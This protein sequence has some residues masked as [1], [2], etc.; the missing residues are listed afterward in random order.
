MVRHY[1]RVNTSWSTWP[2]ICHS[3]LSHCWQIIGH[4]FTF[5]RVLQYGIPFQEKTLAS[6]A[7]IICVPFI[8][9]NLFILLF[10]IFSWIYPIIANLTL[11]WTQYIDCQYWINIENLI[12][13]NGPIIKPCD[14]IE[15]FRVYCCYIREKIALVRIKNIYKIIQI[16]LSK[17]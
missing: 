11:G 8:I 1:S 12:A 17:M 6:H 9:S 3:I 13:S 7:K 2:R 4:L 15:D 14:C 10:V 16:G 5:M